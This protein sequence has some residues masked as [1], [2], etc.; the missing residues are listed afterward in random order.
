MQRICEICSTVCG[1]MTW[2]DFFTN[3][4]RSWISCGSTIVGS[5][6]T[7]IDEPQRTLQVGEFFFFRL[8]TRYVLR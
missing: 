2:Y 8:R 7:V 5:D 1:E 6:D 3:L 4:I